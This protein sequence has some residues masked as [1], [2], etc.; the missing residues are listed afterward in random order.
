MKN[1]IVDASSRL[2]PPPVYVLPTAI[3]TDSKPIG[4]FVMGTNTAPITGPTVTINWN[5]LG[6]PV[7]PPISDVSL[8]LALGHNYLVGHHGVERTFEKLSRYRN[9]TTC[10][11]YVTYAVIKPK[12]VPNCTSNGPFPNIAITMLQDWGQI[13]PTKQSYSFDSEGLIFVREQMIRRP[14][15][16]LCEKDFLSPIILRACKPPASNIQDYDSTISRA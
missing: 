10:P 2:V 16:R 4:I 1:E 12:F 9:A 13:K 5:T 6:A 8:R 3:D 11:S 7:A 14:S 15:A